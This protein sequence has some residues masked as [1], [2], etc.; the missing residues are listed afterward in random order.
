MTDWD[1]H[2]PDA[3]AEAEV[4]PDGALGNTP[5]A[6]QSGVEAGASVSSP[7]PTL[8]TTRQVYALDDSIEMCR[9]LEALLSAAGFTPSCFTRPE[10]FLECRSRLADGL[11]LLDLRMPTVS[12][13]DVLRAMQDDLHRLPT[14]VISAHGDIESAV[15]SLRLGARDFLQ[16]PY[17]AETLIEVVTR[18]LALLDQPLAVT[19]ESNERFG[20]LSPRE[21][22][23]VLALAEG[24]QNKEI[25]GLL[26]ISVRTVEM[27]RARAMQ[28]LGCRSLA[29]VLRLVFSAKDGWG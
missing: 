17:R 14:V 19:T 12:G 8:G 20:H 26:Q 22:E 6:N 27:H 5:P 21:R 25:A 18:E 10:V 15:L 23:V 11:L 1:D 13:L 4:L 29:D 3:E 2:E 7:T 28:R 9:S 24:M 16:K